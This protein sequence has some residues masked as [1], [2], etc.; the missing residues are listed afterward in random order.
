MDANTSP[1]AARAGVLGPGARWLTRALAVVVA[2][3]CW[4]LTAVVTARA[5]SA[6]SGRYM[7]ILNNERV[8]NGLPALTPSGDLSTV[9]QMWAAHM[10]ETGELAHNPQLTSAVTGWRAVGEN[11]GR[12]PTVD[13]LARAFWNSTEHRANILDAGYRSVGVGSAR[14]DGVIWISVV[15]RDPLRSSPPVA[16]AAD[17]AAGDTASGGTASGGTASDSTIAS[18]PT[19]TVTSSGLLTRGST[20]PHVA[21]LQRSLHV[22]ADAV[23]GRATERAV[24][25]FQRQHHLSVDGIFG[26]RTRAALHRQHL[27][28]QHRAQ[29]RRSAERWVTVHGVLAPGCTKRLDTV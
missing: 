16:S 10:A 2:S 11:V 4:F 28:A 21:R 18:A 23:F 1:Y 22:K 20:G 3:S 8:A 15:F 19:P 5:D 26:P 12:G 24:R 17:T 6:D 27:A 14:S 29:A 7:S 9:A 13:D 25:R